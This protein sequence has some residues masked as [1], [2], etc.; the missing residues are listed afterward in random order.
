MPFPNPYRVTFSGPLIP[1]IPSLPPWQKAIKMLHSSRE[2]LPQFFKSLSNVSYL[3]AVAPPAGAAR[4]R[5]PSTRGPA[6][7]T[8]SSVVSKK[9]LIQES[10]RTEEEKHKKF[11]LWTAQHALREPCNLSTTAC[12]PRVGGDAVKKEISNLTS[13][14]MDL[15]VDE[16]ESSKELFQMMK[17][18]DDRLRV[19][20]IKLLGRSFLVLQSGVNLDK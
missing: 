20:A 10:F 13:I 17:A 5:A 11:S 16:N 8:A 9:S 1:T 18:H 6:K 3:P 14:L 15:G 19:L 7:S 2:Y 12:R 4:R